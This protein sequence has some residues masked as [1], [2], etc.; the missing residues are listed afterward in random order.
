MSYDLQNFYK[1]TVSLDWSIGTGNFYVSVKPT[2]S[3]GWVVISPNNASLREIVKFT[4]TGTDSNGDYITISVRGV[5]GTTEQTHS[6]GEPVRMNITA[7]YWDDM[8][9][10]IA[11]IVASGVSNANTTTMG[12][13]EIATDAEVSAGTNTGGTGASLVATPG[14]IFKG[15]TRTS[16]VTTSATPTLNTDN[17]NRLTITAQTT[18]ITS[19]TSSLTGTP[20]DGDK[21][22]I[23][24]T[25]SLGSFAYVNSSSAQGATATL[26]PSLP[27]STADNDVM[28]A[29][30]QCN[31]GTVTT[32]AG[33]T[34]IGTQSYAT[35]GS[36]AYLFRKVAS[37]EGS[38][39]TWTFSNT[40]LNSISIHTYRGGFNSSNPVFTSS[41]TG[42]TTNNT[43]LRAG[44][45]TIP[46]INSPTL[47]FGA[48]EDSLAFTKPTLPSNTTWVEDFDNSKFTS[49][50]TIYPG[51][52]DI[53]KGAT[54]IDGILAGSSQQK[55]AWLVA[56]NSTI[57]ITWGSKFTTT[58]TTLQN[59]STYVFDFVYNSTLAKWELVVLNEKKFNSDFT[60]KDVSSTTTTTLAHKLSSTPG[61]V[62]ISGT[63]VSSTGGST[64]ETIFTDS[65]SSWFNYLDTGTGTVEES[66]QSFR[67][68]TTTGAYLDGIVTV[69]ATNIT[70]TWTKTGSP[71]GTAYLIWEAQI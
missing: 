13:V 17:Y 33:W 57:A 6:V 34:L 35:S 46:F 38:S 63:V 43:T 45:V 54:I 66:G 21:L 19:M 70:I 62:R 7:E 25:P 65:Q 69:D 23:R 31:G 8:N 42:Y 55:A 20:S 2:V 40:V 10:E 58:T 51:K 29:V 64:T 59:G 36:N 61:R 44:T 47:F 41:N 71:T 26:A 14:Q 3:T 5:G 1:A 60:T 30:A 27:T 12:G 24:I 49:V 11:A 50:S 48:N 22:Q 56:L 68:E 53:S 28:F 67:F 39:Y 16:T 32:L 15:V 37:S 4:A 9:D 52:N 18:D